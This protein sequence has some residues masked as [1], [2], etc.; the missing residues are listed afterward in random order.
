MGLDQIK[1]FSSLFQLFPRFT[2]K[3]YMAQKLKIYSRNVNRGFW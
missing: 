1:D 2:H 3:I